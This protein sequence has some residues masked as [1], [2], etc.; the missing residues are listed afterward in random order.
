MTAINTRENTGT[1]G[2]IAGL[3]HDDSRAE[4]AMQRL[5][6][7]GFKSHEIGMASAS[8]QSG[9]NHTGFWNKVSEAGL[10]WSALRAGTGHADFM[11]LES[12]IMQSLHG[13]LCPGIVMKKAGNAP[14]GPSILP[15]IDCCHTISLVLRVISQ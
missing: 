7:A 2:C 14:S 3:F 15:S 5:H 6:D 10:L 11:G 8:P 13:Q 4:L 1:T 9:P 12:G